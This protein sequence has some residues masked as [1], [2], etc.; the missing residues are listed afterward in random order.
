MVDWWYEGRPAHRMKM[1]SFCKRLQ[2]VKY[3][4]KK[5]NK[6]CFGNLKAQRIAPLA[7]LD[8]ITRLIQDQGRT[9]DLSE[10]EFLALKGSKEWELWEEIFWKQKSCIDWLQEGE[11]STAFFHNSV[12]TQR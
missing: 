2:H 6:Q 12:K 5:W 8:N 4:I 1:F 10:A 7:K 3:R 9:L 11:R